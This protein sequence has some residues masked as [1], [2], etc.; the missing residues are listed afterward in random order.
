MDWIGLD[1]GGANIKLADSQGEAVSRPFA[2]WKNPAGLA[3]EL[4]QVLSVGEPDRPLAVTMTGEL[5]DCYA[6]KSEGVRQIVE[7]VVAAAAGRPLHLY[8][9]SGDW[10]KPADLDGRSALAASVAAANWHALAR[11]AAR[12]GAGDFQLLIDI[13]ST[14]T[15]IVPIRQGL[16]R[17][18][19]TTDTD[20]LAS[21]ELVYAGVRRT[22][23][24]SLVSELPLGGQQVPVARELFAT[25]LD[26]YLLLGKMAP[27]EEAHDTADGRPATVD[28]ARARMAR[29][30][31]ASPADVQATEV[32]AMAEKVAAQQCQLVGDAIMKVLATAAAVPDTILLSGEGS[33]L[34][35]QVIGQLNLATDVVSLDDALGPSLATVAP[36]FAVAVLASEE[37]IA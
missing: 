25:T 36:A 6:D 11:F 30:L 3:G 18:T 22:P 21:G 17:S 9:T 27:S 16:P 1:I 28:Q 19:G 7:A 4:A 37:L 12:F 32:V 5:A 20:R 8:S 29:M 2:L 14:T 34:G 23:V 35:R 15:D 24:S 13:G 33:F 31:C 26:V 10:L